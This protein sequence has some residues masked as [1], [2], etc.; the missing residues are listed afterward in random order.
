[1]NLIREVALRIPK[2]GVD[3]DI[4]VEFDGDYLTVDVNG[5][6]ILV[7]PQNLPSLIQALTLINKEIENDG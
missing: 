4:T 7:M 2:F 3:E 6:S 1:V 5:N